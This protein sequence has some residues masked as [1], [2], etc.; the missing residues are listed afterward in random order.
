M[1]PLLIIIGLLVMIEPS[2]R[3]WGLALVFAGVI[4]GLGVRN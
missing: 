1:A 2:S 4:L 3:G